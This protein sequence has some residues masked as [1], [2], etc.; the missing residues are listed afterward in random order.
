MNY[1][2]HG[3]WY[4]EQI[5]LG[6]NYRMTELQA[7]L[8]CSQMSRLNSFVSARRALAERYDND[9]KGLPLT[10]PKV[11]G[12]ESSWHL[13]VIQ[14]HLDKISKTRAEVFSELRERG[15]GVNVHYIPIHLQPYY[16]GFGFAKGDFANAERYY[17]A[18]ISI[19]LFHGM[20]P[21]QQAEVVGALRAVLV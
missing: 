5:D 15:L 3:A 2:A 14:L 17:D 9:L 4:Y 13:Y 21:T 19:P 16:R 20:S 6:Y 10:L 8:G 7:S 11:F 18:A 1:E 12:G